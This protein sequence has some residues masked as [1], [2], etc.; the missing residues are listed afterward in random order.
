MSF[1]VPE[2]IGFRRRIVVAITLSFCLGGCVNSDP[3]TYSVQQSRIAK[4]ND[5]TEQT[6]QSLVSE[7]ENSNTLGYQSLT[8]LQQQQRRFAGQMDLTSKFSQQGELE[9]AAENMELAQFIHLV[10][11][12]LLK[13]NYVI[14]D[15]VAATGQKV[16]LQVQTP[17][18][19]RKLFTMA[20]QILADK[21]VAITE[22]EDVFYIH[23]AE[24]AKT[25]SIALGFGRN[26]NDVPQMPGT[27]TQIVPILYN[28]DLSVERVLT[29][30]TNTRVEEV[31]GQ[32]A[33]SIQ[34][35]RTEILRALD[36]LNIL[37]APAA[38]G[39]HVGLLRL[40]YISVE[41]F[42]KQ[43]NELL[44]SEGLPV[45]I[46]KAGNRNMV[47]IPLEQIGAV[48]LFAA[49]ELYI[50]RVQF[51]ASKLDQPSQGSARS[52]FIYHPRYARASDLG[53]SVGALFGQQ[54][55]SANQ[56]RDTQ[57]AQNMPVTTQ[58]NSANVRPGAGDR[59]Q[60]DIQVSTDDL[61]MTVDS[62]SNSLIFY[63][64]GKKY[65]N[66]LPMVK[67]LDVMPKQILLEAT[68]AE[69]TLTDEFAMGVEFAIRNGM[70]GI[71]TSGALGVAKIGGLNIG[72]NNGLDKILLQLTAT[73]SRVN[74]LSSPSIV[75]RDGVN[76][77]IGV[78]SDIPTVGSTTIN[79]GTD[80]Q[81]TT[82][83]YRK[84]GVEFSVTPTIS[85]QGLVVMAIE[86][87]I[88]NTVDGGVQVAGSP[89]FFERSIRTEVIAQ[90]GQSI[91]L[92]GL[93]S[94][95]NTKSHSK[96]PFLGDL[97]ILGKLFQSEKDSVSKTELI[98]LITPK[99]LD[100]TTQWQ[101]IS[102]KLSQQMSLLRLT[103]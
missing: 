44:L 65:Q 101:A 57:S 42:V 53:G 98:I 74:L 89:S 81:S 43:L 14:A 102:D 6:N 95:N 80:T 34:G 35:E 39:K 12:D 29:E 55:S 62:R 83:T 78:G 41:E 19:A 54:N 4:G 5:F 18:G 15:D 47:V 97:P 103:D 10:F 86:Q 1:L 82:V 49:D 24:Q 87:K 58:P 2:L 96:V 52:Y 90:S 64:T 51:W 8:P 79:P 63:T 25:A 88:S 50:D 61:M 38:R 21:R 45:D 40:T 72:Y 60:N 99:V 3:K 77:V 59:S 84:T 22:R 76:A 30:L 26:P 92:G 48:A 32:S 7:I 33:Y 93:M 70:L 9:L 68:I 75:V 69:V 91:L 94:E 37:D 71:G 17:V 73:D 20:M 56:T 36:L 66:I 85:A 31:Q 11:G 23:K 16:S 100:N 13:V 28:R 46:G 67:R 27:L